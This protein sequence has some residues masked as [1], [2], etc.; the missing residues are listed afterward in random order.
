MSDP[1]RLEAG[2]QML[3]EA[4][5]GQSA[6]TWD[7]LGIFTILAIIVVGTFPGQ[8][9]RPMSTRFYDTDLTERLGE[10]IRRPQRVSQFSAAAAV[11]HFDG[12]AAY[13]QAEGYS[14][15]RATEILGKCCQLNA[16]LVDRGL[17]RCEELSESLIDSRQS[18]QNK[19]IGKMFVYTVRN[20]RCNRLIL[21]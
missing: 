6:G 20:V 4:C 8:R 19:I 1:V 17:T 18:Q 21:G 15:S 10:L 14:C 2:V 7:L 3:A 13:L 11:S 5:P 16:F 12:F 9:D